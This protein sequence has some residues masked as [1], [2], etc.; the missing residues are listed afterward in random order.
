M[1]TSADRG[2]NAFVDA[3]PGSAYMLLPHCEGNDSLM[4]W[5]FLSS[6]I[7][8]KMSTQIY[9]NEPFQIY[10]LGG[11]QADSDFLYKDI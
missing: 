2:G 10:S 1:L 6:F 3:G 4:G 5:S 8:Y 9:T 11:F 7:R